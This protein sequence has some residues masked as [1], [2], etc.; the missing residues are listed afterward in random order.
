METQQAKTFR[1]DVVEDKHFFGSYFNLALD[2]IEK[3]LHAAR[4][5]FLSK[6]EGNKGLF[7]KNLSAYDYKVR[8]E[9]LGSL[10]NVCLIYT[11]IKQ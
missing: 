5:R 6:E 7:P 2:N 11:Y 3:V 9:E 1:H 8:V 10:L 4:E